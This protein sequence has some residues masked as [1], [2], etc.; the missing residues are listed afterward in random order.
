MRHHPAETRSC[1]MRGSR[2]RSQRRGTLLQ[3]AA[4][5]PASS[6]TPRRRAEHRPWTLLDQSPRSAT[7]HGIRRRLECTTCQSDRAAPSNVAANHQPRA[8]AV[9]K[10]H[11]LHDPRPRWTAKACAPRL[12]GNLAPITH[13]FKVG[14]E[15]G[16]RSARSAPGPAWP[17]AIRARQLA[18]WARNSLG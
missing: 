9:G 2:Y 1:S 4:E 5:T 6:R 11:G 8:Q 13:P 7:R 10:P 3:A 18:N 17:S 14:V 16:H 15:L 12:V